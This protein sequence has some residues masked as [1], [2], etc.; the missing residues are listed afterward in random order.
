MAFF[1]SDNP[2]ALFLALV[3]VVAVMRLLLAKHSWFKGGNAAYITAALIGMILLLLL[4]RPLLRLLSFGVPF[5]VLIAIFV[6]GI[7]G[8]FLALGTPNSSIWQMLKGSGLI[9]TTAIVVFVCIVALAASHVWGERLLED[10]TVSFADP[11]MPQEETAKIDFTPVFQ[12][13]VLYM[14]MI[15][16]VLAFAFYFVMMSR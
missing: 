12:P 3:L 14:I 7:G 5:L 1:T 15:T 2:I 9:R 4:Y 6:V 16:I 13:S 8:I 10:K 11:L